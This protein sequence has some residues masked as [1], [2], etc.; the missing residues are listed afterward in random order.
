[1][2]DDEVEI[3]ESRRDVIDVADVERVLVRAE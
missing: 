1:M 2:L 3:L